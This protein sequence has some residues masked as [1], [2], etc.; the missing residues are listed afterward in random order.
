[1]SPSAPAF[2]ACRSPSFFVL[3]FQFWNYRMLIAAMCR[4]GI[5]FAGS[6]ARPALIATL[7]ATLITTL[8]TTLIPAAL[9][10]P[11]ISAV[12]APFARILRAR[13]LNSWFLSAR[14]LAGVPHLMRRL[15]A[16]RRSSSLNFVGVFLIFEFHE[17][18]YIEEG[19]SLQSQIHK[20]RLHSRQNA[21]NASVID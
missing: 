18:S 15:V 2:S 5:S 8:I 10:A 6:L 13:F 20:C 1:M 12:P 14:F 3:G 4:R 7:I 9:L 11:P 19:V 17:V 16:G 21:R